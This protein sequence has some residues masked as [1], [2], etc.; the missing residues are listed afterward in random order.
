MDRFSFLQEKKNKEKK[1]NQETAW[2]IWHKS[3]T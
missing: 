3:S 2:P 1:T